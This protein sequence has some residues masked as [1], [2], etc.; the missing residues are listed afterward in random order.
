M[1]CIRI[2]YGTIAHI[3]EQAFSKLNVQTIGVLESDPLRIEQ[4]RQAG[5]KPLGSVEEA[6]ALHP[7][8]FDICTPTRV[9][10]E[11]LQA[12]SALNPYANILIE[13]P[14]CDFEDIALVNA[15]L[16]SHKG[17]I[18]VNE[19]Y[20]SS[21]ITQAV[22]D[23]VLAL[24]LTPTRVIVEMTKHRGKDY[25]KGRFIDNALGALGYEGSHLLALIGELGE[26]YAAAEILE[27]DIDSV[28]LKTMGLSH[29]GGAFM[30]YIATNGCI[31]E[32][33]TSMSGIIGYP[34]PPFAL[35]EQRIAEDDASTRYRI[36]RIDGIDPQN[37]P[38]Q[39]IGCFEPIGV[40]PRRQ[41]CLLVFRNYVLDHQINAIEDDT[42]IQHLNR[43]MR[44]FSN[45][46]PNPCSVRRALQDVTKL[47]EWARS[48]W[49][50]MDDSND[51][52]GSEEGSRARIDESRRFKIMTPPYIA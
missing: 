34:C 15:V 7:D 42:M 1:K 13:K 39:I 33:Y 18:V 30:K 37:T 48:G 47:H 9:H 19:N 51:V 46:G 14:I 26:A 28:A 16:A 32:L 4:I 36:L 21:A 8:F 50:D 45:I 40:L 24:A 27:T 22:K 44:C 29:Q 5:L 52:L 43:S 35:P 20:C 49:F 10:A 31:V 23:K 3:H 25:L 2:G 38:Y 11:I 12:I 17:H 6:I 41:G